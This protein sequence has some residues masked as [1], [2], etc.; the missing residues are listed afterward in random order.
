[1]W[2]T[3]PQSLKLRALDVI[4]EGSTRLPVLMA[5]FGP[6]FPMTDLGE[7]LSGSCPKLFAPAHERCDI[8]FPGL[9]A[10]MA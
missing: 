3:G 4:E 2:P 5:K 8:Y 10:L 9:A 6:D 7:R 1:M